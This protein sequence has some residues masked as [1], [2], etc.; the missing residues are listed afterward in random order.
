M[1]TLKDISLVIFYLTVPISLLIIIKKLSMSQET[2]DSLMAKV[3]RSE[4]A[5]TNIRADIQAIKD[6]LP[7]SGGL[8]AAEVA[9]LSDRLETAAAGAEALDSENP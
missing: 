1:D 7:T 8:T 3:T 4:T 6:G 9:T 2:L 5:L